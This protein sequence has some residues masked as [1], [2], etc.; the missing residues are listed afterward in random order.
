MKQLLLIT[1]IFFISHITLY[2][3]QACDVKLKEIR[4]TYSGDCENGKANGKGKSIGTDVYEG[5]F[6]DGYP[7]GKGTYTWKDGH[8][9]IGVFKKGNKEGKGNMYYE[10]AAGDDSIVSG[11]W[12]KDKY[13]G[14]Y[15]KKFVLMSNTTHV[16]KV[17][18]NLIDS[19]GE[20][21]YIHVHK[22][23]SS[24]SIGSYPIAVSIISS[25]SVI[26]GTYQ[27]KNTQIQTNSS[28]TRLTQVQY[29]FR[30]I[31]YLSNGE[32]A[33]VLINEK[34]DYDVNIDLQ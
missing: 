8:Y 9:Y 4:G 27:A 28:L 15:E 30:A 3:Q 33:D 11:Y 34:G 20:N 12:K 13:Y 17:E 23:A 32:N 6:K 14:Q 31:F 22:L 18:C 2:A 29:P 21:I 16:N 24:Q 19:K 7:E 1:A 10:N 25:I 26:A 5:E